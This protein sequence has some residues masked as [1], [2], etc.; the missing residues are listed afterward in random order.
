MRISFVSEQAERLLGYPIHRWLAEP[1]F[2][3]DHIHDDDRDSVLESCRRAIRESSRRYD[4]E[5]RM[6]A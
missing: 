3:Q 5:Y 4:V 1:H 2:W 6:I